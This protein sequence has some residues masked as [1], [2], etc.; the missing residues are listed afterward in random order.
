GSFLVTSSRQYGQTCVSVRAR[1]TAARRRRVRLGAAGATRW[2]AGRAAA[3]VRLPGHKR[4]RLVR[5]R[6]L[7]SANAVRIVGRRTSCAART[8]G[9]RGAATL[10]AGGDGGGA[11]KV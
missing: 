3:A 5:T 4:T 7:Q 10:T 1:C 11:S 6:P 2:R 9:R 8:R